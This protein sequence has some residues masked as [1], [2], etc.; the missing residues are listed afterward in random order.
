[1]NKFERA[2]SFVKEQIEQKGAEAVAREIEELME[3]KQL[4]EGPTLS[5]MLAVDAALP[6]S[7]FFDSEEELQGEEFELCSGIIKTHVN[8]F[9][10]QAFDAVDAI[11]VF[12]VQGSVGFKFYAND[13]V[14]DEAA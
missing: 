4:H 7:A 3:S 8:V 1:M 14:L 2:L 6:Y 13:D 9:E 5:D 10:G 11:R 12:R